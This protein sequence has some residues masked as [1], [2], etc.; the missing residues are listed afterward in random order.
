MIEHDRL[1]RL[2][3]RA[4]LLLSFDSPIEDVCA[5][6]SGECSYDELFLIIKAGEIILQDQL[7]S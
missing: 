1:E 3:Q 6:L 7:N 4:A 2:I 5:S